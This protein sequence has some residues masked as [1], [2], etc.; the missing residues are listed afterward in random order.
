MIHDESPGINPPE[1]GPAV[2]GACAAEAEGRAGGVEPAFVPAGPWRKANPKG[3]ETQW[4]DAQPLG[5]AGRPEH[6]R[7]PYQIARGLMEVFGKACHRGKPTCGANSLL[8]QDMAPWLEDCDPPWPE[9]L[10]KRCIADAIR[11]REKAHAEEERLEKAYEIE[12]LFYHTPT[13]LLLDADDEQEDWVR[14]LVEGVLPEQQ[15]AVLGGPLKSLKTSTA[16]DL[17]VSVATGAPFLGVFRVPEPKHVT[18]F[19][20]ESGEPVIRETVRRVCA[21]KGVRPADV[22]ARLR[23]FFKLPRLDDPGDLE[24]LTFILRYHKARLV[25]LDPLYRCLLTSGAGN[26]TS[27]YSMGPILERVGE[28]CLGAGCTPV[29]VHHSGKNLPAGKPMQLDDLAFAGLPEFARAW[30]LLSRRKEYDPARPGEHDLIMNYGG[31]AGHSGVRAVR[32]SEGELQPD[33]TGRRWE[34][35][36]RPLEEAGQ[37]GGKP[38]ARKARPGA[39][40]ERNAQAV[41][42]AIVALRKA[43]GAWVRR[44]RVQTRTGLSGNSLGAAIAW[45]EGRGALEVRRKPAKWGRGEVHYLRLTGA[46]EVS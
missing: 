32:V 9:E 22:E 18:L 17:A 6:A 43:R 2:N 5:V 33:F 19:S 1:D 37:D 31:C 15:P 23:V 11:D 25:V 46:W 3:F 36:V 8:K 16:V 29:L 42:E 27:L 35:T 28:A 30:V 4:L 13:E 38:R 14:W 34:V 24:R 10:V 44:K 12:C 40:V 20:G 41:R 7:L 21:A 26:A 45:L 39:A